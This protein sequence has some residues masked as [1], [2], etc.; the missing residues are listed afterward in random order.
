MLSDVFLLEKSDHIP[1][2]GSVNE[3]GATTVIAVI[4]RLTLT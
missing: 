2:E 4:L 3:D 1:L